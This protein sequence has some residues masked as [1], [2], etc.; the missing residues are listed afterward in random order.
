MGK[1]SRSAGSAFCLQ[2]APWGFYVWGVIYAYQGLGAVYAMMPSGYGTDG[3][4][5]RPPALRKPLPPA[6]APSRCAAQA[7]PSHP[8]PPYLLPSHPPALNP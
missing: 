3:S 8:L 7:H 2:P 4:K 5:A 1:L 6:R